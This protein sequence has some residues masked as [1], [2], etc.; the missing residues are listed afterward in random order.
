MYVRLLLPPKFSY[1]LSHAAF[2]K[3]KPASPNASNLFTSAASC[4]PSTSF[5]ELYKFIDYSW[6]PQLDAYGSNNDNKFSTTHLRIP[7]SR[8]RNALTALTD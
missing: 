1:C 6:K 5:T 2:E 7:D 8:L 3:V 4:S